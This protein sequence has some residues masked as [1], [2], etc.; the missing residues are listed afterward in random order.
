MEKNA[1]VIKLAIFGHTHEDEFRVVGGVPLKLVGS[2]SPNNGNEPSFTVASIDRETSVMR[3]Y[4]VF[5]AS[6]LTGVEATWSREY[7]FGETYHEP[8]FTAVS[9]EKLVGRFRADAGASTAESAAYEQ[10]FFPSR[11]GSSPLVLAWPQYV[12]ALDHMGE[13]DFKGCVCAQ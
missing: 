2:V 6:N 4:A 10:N 9:L 8:E 13:A 1:D 12:C 11:T 3:D 7:R 5:T